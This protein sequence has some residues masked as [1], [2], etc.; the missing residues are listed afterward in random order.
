[1]LDAPTTPDL[2]DDVDALRALLIE[3]RAQTAKL[4]ATVRHHELQIEKL[5]LQLAKLRRMQFGRSSEKLAQQIEQL[6]L[7][8]EELETPVTLPA[9]RAT[10]TLPETP[11]RRALPEHLPRESV[12]HAS[13]CTCLDCGGALRDLGED[14]SEILDYVPSHWKVI[15][16]V[17]P[18]RI[19]EGCRSIHQAPAPSRPIA[20]SHAGAGLLAHVLVSKYADHRVPRTHRLGRRC[21]AV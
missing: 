18:K 14:V 5:K 13:V 11:A 20:R 7:L 6:E 8:I 4:S 10:S 9:R 2:P 16:H 12:M 3:S 15:R 1:M 21:G 17:R 19:C